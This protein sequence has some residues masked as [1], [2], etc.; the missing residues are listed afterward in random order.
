MDKVKKS[1]IQPELYDISLNGGFTKY[2]YEGSL[3]SS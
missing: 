2:T 1:W 3:Y